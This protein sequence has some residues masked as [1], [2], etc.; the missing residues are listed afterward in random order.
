[1]LHSRH[2]P[3]PAVG[4]IWLN[5]IGLTAKSNRPHP[6]ELF[7]SALSDILVDSLPCPI[8]LPAYT[9]EPADTQLRNQWHLVL[10]W[11][12]VQDERWRPWLENQSVGGIPARNY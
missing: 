10:L 9:L 4:S 12:T 11:S 2:L 1:M 3:C 5:C 8:V 7:P 6:K